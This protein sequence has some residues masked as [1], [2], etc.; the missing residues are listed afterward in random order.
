ML[1]VGDTAP[2][3]SLENQH[4]ETVT[5][6]SLAGEGDLILYF[7]P[8]DFS[9]VCTAEACTFRDGYDGIA[10][11]GAQI[12]GI[13]P[14]SASSHQR[15]AKANNIP[16][17]LLA[18]PRKT[19]IRQYGVNGPMGLGVRRVTFLLGPDRLIK[20]RVVSDFFAGSHTA[21]MKEVLAG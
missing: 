2:D 3:F 9:P 16:F 19:V 12:V 5:L 4:G 13:S 1:K 8:A 14:Q 18:D 11:V 6:S 17:P 20:N 10:E 7:Y 21:V 15:F